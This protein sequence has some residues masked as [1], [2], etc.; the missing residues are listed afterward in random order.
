M[1]RLSATASRNACPIA[2]AQSSMVWCSS[3]PRSP[4]QSTVNAKPPCLPSCSSMWSKKPSPVRA[5]GSAVRS[6]STD[7][8]I[9]VSRVVRLTRAV[10]GA[11][12]SAWAIPSQSHSPPNCAV[13]SWNARMPMLRANALSVSRSPTIAERAQSIERSCSNG[14]ASAMPGLRVGAFSSGSDVSINTSRNAMPWLSNSCII[15]SCGPS[16]T[17]RGNCDRPRPSWLVTMTN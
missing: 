15:R 14:S 1:P 5:C 6:R 8:S 4:V 11:S 12:A 13:F 9:R 17:A 2:S 7:T 10:R 3:T 16:N